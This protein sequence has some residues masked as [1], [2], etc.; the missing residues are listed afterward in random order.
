MELAKKTLP[1]RCLSGGGHPCFFLISSNNLI[2]SGN[3][4]PFLSCCPHSISLYTSF[5]SLLKLCRVLSTEFCC[6]QVKVYSKVISYPHHKEISSKWIQVENFQFKS[7][8]GRYWFIFCFLLDR[9]FNQM[10]SSLKTIGH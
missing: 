2:S 5:L 1:T 6:V 3:I 7:R 9:L 10:I 8:F 4:L